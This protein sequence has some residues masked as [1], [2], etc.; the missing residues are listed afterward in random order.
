VPDNNKTCEERIDTR[1]ENRLANL[2]VSEECP[3]CMGSGE[4]DCPHCCDIEVSDDIL[5]DTLVCDVCKDTCSITCPE[6]HGEGTNEDAPR[7]E[8]VLS[9]DTHTVYDVCL[10]TGGPADGF[11]LKRKDREWV[12]GEYYFL[13]WYDG[14]P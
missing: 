5:A 8:D 4:V 14:G 11:C 13:D 2:D 7:D 1:L 9:V 10:S 12:G 3:K 6:C